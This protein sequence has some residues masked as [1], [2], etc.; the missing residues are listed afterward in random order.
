MTQRDGARCLMISPFRRYLSP[1]RSPL[2]PSTTWSFFWVICRLNC[3]PAQAG[4]DKYE[5]EHENIA[6]ST[7]LP[8]LEEMWPTETLF[9][10]LNMYVLGSTIDLALFKRDALILVE[11]KDCSAPFSANESRTWQTSEHPSVSLK[12]GRHG[13][14]FRQIKHYRH[15]FIQFSGHR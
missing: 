11:L 12:G 10:V 13:N 15:K 2:A 6:V 1:A 8:Q 7:L 5:F 9:V 14:P 4:N 3:G